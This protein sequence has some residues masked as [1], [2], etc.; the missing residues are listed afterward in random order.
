RMVVGVTGQYFLGHDVIA[1]IANGS[2]SI[3]Q[4]KRQDI[5]ARSVP[6]IIY[7]H[8]M[9]VRVDQARDNVLTLP[10][11]SPCPRWSFNVLVRRNDGLNAPARDHNGPI[12]EHRSPDRI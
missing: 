11:N 12:W 9:R 6:K 4:K 3:D 7:K 1:D 8:Q 2:H 5:V 10:V